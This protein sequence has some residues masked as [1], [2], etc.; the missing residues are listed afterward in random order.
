MS[1][2]EFWV[3]GQKRVSRMPVLS[4]RQ[5]AVRGAWRPAVAAH[6]GGNTQTHTEGPGR[7]ATQEDR[8]GDVAVGAVCFAGT[9]T[10]RCRQAHGCWAHVCA[11]QS[12]PPPAEQRVC[13]LRA[14]PARPPAPRRVPSAQPASF[15]CRPFARSPHYQDTELVAS[16]PG[17]QAV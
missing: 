9:G 16:G 3:S 11:H 2:A 1:C 10:G 15:P 17:G 13:G 6:P 7:S 4:R 8:V 14:A 12:Q 5:E